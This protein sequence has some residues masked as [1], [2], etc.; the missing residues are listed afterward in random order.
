M[1]RLREFLQEQ[2]DVIVKPLDMMGGS[3]IF[4][5]QQDDVNTGVVLET[6]TDH[7][8]RTVMAQRFIPEISQGD[9]RILL[10]DGEVVPYALARI[11]AKG[12][13][14][15]NLAAGG[16]GVGK[17]LSERDRWICQQLAPTLKDMGLLFVGID[18]I[19]DYLTEINVTS[20]TCIRELDKLYNLDIAGQLMDVIAQRRQP[21]A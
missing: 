1:A 19:G 5:L 18:V 7:G 16:E 17:A 4:R 10:V 15:G 9:K 8:R 12:E 14:R 3:S 2:A 20:P 21:K 6:I 11:P 13:F